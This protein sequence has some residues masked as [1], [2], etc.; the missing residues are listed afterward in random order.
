MVCYGVEKPEGLI[1]AVWLRLSYIYILHAI[2]LLQKPFCFFKHLANKHRQVHWL[3]SFNFFLSHGINSPLPPTT[4]HSVSST[5]SPVNYRFFCSIYSL[6]SVTFLNEEDDM[7]G[8]FSDA[9][10]KQGCYGRGRSSQPK[11]SRFEKKE[12]IK[13]KYRFIPDN[14]SSLEQACIILLG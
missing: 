4:T 5:I 1:I 12:S 8:V 10:S 3:I 14:F 9:Q 7:G 2:V 11:G 13:Q 6:I